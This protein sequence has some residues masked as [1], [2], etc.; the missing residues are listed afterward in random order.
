MNAPAPVLGWNQEILSERV[1]EC[2]TL[3]LNGFGQA[4]I[5]G[6]MRIFPLIKENQMRLDSSIG[7][8]YHGL[9]W[10]FYR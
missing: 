1:K 7:G 10:Q 4:V 3:G 5:S 6:I 2:N 9:E 8:R